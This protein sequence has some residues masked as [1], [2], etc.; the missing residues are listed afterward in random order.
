MYCKV[1]E[2]NSI[3]II[4]LSLFSI[5]ETTATGFTVLG[6]N[7]N[8]SVSLIYNDEPEERRF[9]KTY[10]I[11]GSDPSLLINAK[12]K[13]RLHH[14][15]QPTSYML[16]PVP[17]PREGIIVVADSSLT[18]FASVSSSKTQ[19]TIPSMEITAYILDRVAHSHPP[20]F[21]LST[22]AGDVYRLAVHN[23]GLKFDKLDGKVGTW[24]MRAG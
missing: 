22:S 4:D 5:E 9:T 10:D 20:S 16:I 8:P 7:L 13:G 21:L 3:H 2:G 19:K 18:Y 17:S 1:T 11:N 15:L 12:E 24:M 6:T 14:E 23:K